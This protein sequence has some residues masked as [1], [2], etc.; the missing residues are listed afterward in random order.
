MTLFDE[1]IAVLPTMSVEPRWFVFGLTIVG[2]F[3]VGCG[4]RRQQFGLRII[5]LFLQLSSFYYFLNSVWYPFSVS[6]VTNSYFFHCFIIVLTAMFSAYMMEKWLIGGLKQ[7]DNIVYATLFLLGVVAWYAG[8]I[9]E[10]YMHIVLFERLSGLLLLISAT[11]I[12]VGLLAENIGWVR[13]NILLLIQ[14]PVMCLLLLLEYF[15]GVETFSL[16]TGWGTTVWPIAL[17]IQYR[18]LTVLDDLSWRKTSSVYHLVSFWLLFVFCN[19]ELTIIVT[20]KFSNALITHFAQ[21][22]LGCGAMLFI[23]AF[24]KL[25]IWPVRRFPSLY[26]WGGSAGIIVVLLLTVILTPR[27]IS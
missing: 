2:G 3:L 26:L 7:W 27:L 21:I 13:L 16:L 10:I 12:A 11:S 20:E 4:V 17:F 1:F 14:L 25:H 15:N 9:R 19:K 23:A 18:I 6:I 5:G 24:K 8:G 22:L